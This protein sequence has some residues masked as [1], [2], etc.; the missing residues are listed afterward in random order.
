MELWLHETV[1]YVKLPPSAHHRVLV[2]LHSG[3]TFVKV[4]DRLS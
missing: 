3:N 2:R 4:A 1:I